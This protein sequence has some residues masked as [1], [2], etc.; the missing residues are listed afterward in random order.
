MEIDVGFLD[1][2]KFQAWDSV[3][4]I[5]ALIDRWTPGKCKTEKEYEKS[6]YVFLHEELGDLQITK[7][8]AQGRIRADLMVSD[9][10]V[11][12]LKHN[13]NSTAKYQR[14]I[15]QLAEYKEWRGRIVV[16]L[17]G[18]TDPNLRKRLSEYLKKEGL[19]DELLG[20]KV[21]VLEK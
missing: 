19:E 12:E 5:V 21:T 9:K 8:Y 2:L 20:D 18:D 15:G 11:V 13:L 10:V 14:L 4:A 17:V 1:K 16:L 6:L 3:G 7:Q